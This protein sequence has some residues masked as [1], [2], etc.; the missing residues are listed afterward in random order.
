MGNIAF[1]LLAFGGNVFGFFFAFVLTA[2]GDFLV[3]GFAV[4]THLVA[5]VG[6]KLSLS[7]ET[8]LHLLSAIFRISGLRGWFLVTFSCSVFTF[9]RSIPRA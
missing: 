7:K 4:S 5:F 8:N 9:K 2:A 1:F 6:V 3:I